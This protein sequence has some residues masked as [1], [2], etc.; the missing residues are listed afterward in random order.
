MKKLFWIPIALILSGCAQGK[1][2]IFQTDNKYQK[3]PT[4]GSNVQL[5]DYGPAPEL[6]NQ[7]W[8]N[9]DK[10]LRL[11]NLRGKVILLEMWTFG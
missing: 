3:T 1:M 8:L 6:T 2:N 7:V 9:S 11:K 4:E 5:K 10:P